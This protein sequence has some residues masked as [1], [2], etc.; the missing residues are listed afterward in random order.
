[1]EFRVR[2]LRQFGEMSVGRAGFSGDQA[3]RREVPQAEGFVEAVEAAASQPADVKGC[4]AQAAD[5]GAVMQY[6]VEAPDQRL[7]TCLP[8]GEA[9]GNQGS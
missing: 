9:R 7:E 2:I 6:G 3:G 4:R 1:M 5:V 8:V